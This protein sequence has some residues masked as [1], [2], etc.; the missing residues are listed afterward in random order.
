MKSTL[1]KRLHAACARVL[2]GCGNPVHGQ[3][4]TAVRMRRPYERS[5]SLVLIDTR[6][7]RD[8]LEARR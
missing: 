7:L 3:E 5:P 6:Q 8:V 4:L 1:L 2:P